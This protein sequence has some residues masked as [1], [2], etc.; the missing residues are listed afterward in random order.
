MIDTNFGSTLQEE[1][2][3]F[4]LLDCGMELMSTWNNS[5]MPNVFIQSLFF[6]IFKM[7][8]DIIYLQ[9]QSKFQKYYQPNKFYTQS[10][11]IL[12]IN[13]KTFMFLI[14][15]SGQVYSRWYHLFM[16]KPNE[17]MFHLISHKINFLKFFII[18]FLLL[19]FSRDTISNC[20]NTT[21][22]VQ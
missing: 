6:S 10:L 9:N 7:K 17:M 21:V 18:K 5:A 4:E 13:Y 2:I 1:K 20:P 16:S 14:I 3:E 22:S 12:D 19:S 15:F 8:H 11:N